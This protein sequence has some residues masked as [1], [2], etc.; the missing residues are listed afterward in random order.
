MNIDLNTV[1]V[2]AGLAI[3]GAT[4]FFTRSADNRKQGERLAVLETKVTHFGAAL[5]DIKKGIGL[6]RRC[7]DCERALDK[8]NRAA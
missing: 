6:T 3:H 4:F 5:D 1:V 7:T 2:L 8:E